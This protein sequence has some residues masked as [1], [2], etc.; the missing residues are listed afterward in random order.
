MDGT[1]QNYTLD[2]AAD[3]KK[4]PLKVKQGDTNSRQARISLVA[5][6]EPWTIPF[7]CQIHINV[8][9]N[10][11][12]YANATCTVEDEHTVLAPITEQMTAVPGTQLGELFFLGVDGDIRSQTFPLVVWNAVSDLDRMVSSD[13]YQA[14]KDALRDVKAST[15]TADIAAQY[16]T[17]QGDQARDAAQRAEDA[18]DSIQAAVDA[19]AAAKISET[20]AKTS[21]T[22]SAQ[23]KQ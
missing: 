8:H 7:G 22:A 23:T 21:E 14:L 16:A 15:E 1:I 11:G 17:E 4:E 12:T 6:N 18:A 9:K 5:F 3:T 13:D 10:D 2:M 20:N 19:A